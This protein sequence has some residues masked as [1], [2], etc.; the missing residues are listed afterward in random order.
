MKIL[1]TG[2]AGFIGSAVVRHIIE[3]T[4]DEV[5]VMDCLTYAGNLESLAPV[6]G[7]ERYS[8]S[9]TDITD[10]AAVAAQFSE[11]HPDIVMHL[12]AESHVDRSIDGPA[13]FIQ[14]NVI[15]TFTLLEAAR[16]YWSGLV[17]EQ[18]Q[19]FRFHHISTDEVYGDLHGTD[20][21]FTEETSYAPS[22]PY[23]ASKA[24]SDHLVRAWNRTYGLPV[25]VTNCSN[26]YGPYHFPEKLIPL[27]I[28]NALAGKPLPVYGNGEQIRD[29]LYVEDHARAL[30]KVAT[31]GKSGETYNI[32]GHNERKNID[33]VRTICT[34]LDKV[35]AQKPGNITHFADL[36]TFVT[37]RPGH[38]LRYAIDATKIQRDLGWVPQETFE[39]GIEKTVHW[40]LNNQTWWQRVLDGSYA[41]ERLGLNK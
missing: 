3:N 23:S 1:V 13:A 41:G 20:D 37:D 10:A 31:E 17:E 19:A 16:H 28:L 25:V 29:W 21:L 38:D 4:L 18:K 32:G 9:Q 7:S 6:A 33:V 24:G 5:R 34:I 2:G 22:S 11:F 35:V 36:I 15:G 8:F 12:A 40:Y 26:N 27:T 39:S 14:T 30:Y